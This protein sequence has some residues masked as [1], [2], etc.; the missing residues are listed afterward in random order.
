MLP[1]SHG[2][3]ESSQITPTNNPSICRRHVI[4][5]VDLFVRCLP[6]NLTPVR[7]AGY[8]ITFIHDWSLP[9]GHVIAMIIRLPFAIVVF[10]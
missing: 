5:L 10:Q 2:L 8:H 9:T 3:P 4:V 7:S 1:M 6:F